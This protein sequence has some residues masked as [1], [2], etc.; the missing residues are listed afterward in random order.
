MSLLVWVSIGGPPHLPSLNLSVLSE[1]R[2]CAG[3][4]LGSHC[5]WIWAD[6]SSVFPAGTR[7]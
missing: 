5:V 6:M 7:D 4:T 1:A 2:P 3:P